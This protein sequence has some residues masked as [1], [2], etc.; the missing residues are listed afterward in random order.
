MKKYI[1]SKDVDI[2]AP[3]WLTEQIEYKHA[4]IIYRVDKRKGY[5]EIKGVRVGD[6]TAKIGDTLLFDGTRLSIER[7]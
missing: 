5:V 3:S 6:D 1:V 7:R 4:K 2:L